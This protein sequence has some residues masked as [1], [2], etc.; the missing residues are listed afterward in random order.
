LTAATIREY[1]QDMDNE[2][3]TKLVDKEMPE[4]GPMLEELQSA[5]R[6]IKNTIEPTLEILNEEKEVARSLPKN[7]KQYLMTKHNLQLSYCSYIMMYLM[8]KVEGHPT[9]NHPVVFKLAHIKQLFDKLQ[10]LDEKMQKAIAQVLMTPPQENASSN[11][12]SAVEEDEDD[13]SA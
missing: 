4:I 1:A 9:D 2:M 3:L 6:S 8:M 7:C 12:E 5:M 10:P 11:E 13:N